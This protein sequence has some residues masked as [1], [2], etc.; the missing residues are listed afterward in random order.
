MNGALPL[1][2]RR[3]DTPPLDSLESGP[4]ATRSLRVRGSS[5]APAR[6]QRGILDAL[7]LAV[8]DFATVLRQCGWAELRPAP[9]EIFQI[10]VGRLCNMT[11]RHCRRGSRSHGRTC[12]QT[13]DLCWPP[14]TTAHTVDITGG[15][16]N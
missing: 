3:E 11:C 16:R 13:V 12:R 5:L 14:D 10:N 8:P 4:T 7:P 2:L 1:V 9:L 6:A 15:A